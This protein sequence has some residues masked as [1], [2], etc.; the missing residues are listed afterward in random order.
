M[1]G[2]HVGDMITRLFEGRLSESESNEVYAHLEQCADCE[3]IFERHAKA[4]QQLYAV[5]DGDLAPASFDRVAARLAPPS[6][7]RASRRFGWAFAAALAAAGSVFF[8]VQ[9]SEDRMNQR[10]DNVTLDA[11]YGIRVLRL[12]VEQ[13]DK[14]QVADAA[15]SAI[16]E[17]DI[18]QIVYSTGRDARLMKFGVL[19]DAGRPLA[20]IGPLPVELDAVEVRLSS[21]LDVGAWPTGPVRFVAVFGASSEVTAKHRWGSEPSD[22]DVRVRVVEGQVVAK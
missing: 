8:V 13:D 1:S 11:K 9:P 22:D 12:R 4:E 7:P 14:V 16:A 3:R 6:P 15:S 10:G 21:R 19:D 18:L 20:E 5:A 17:G 2:Q